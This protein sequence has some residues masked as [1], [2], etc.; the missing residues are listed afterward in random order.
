MTLISLNILKLL[1]VSRVNDCQQLGAKN[2]G[3]GLREGIKKMIME[4]SIIVGGWGQ[5]WTNVPLSFFLEKMIT[6]K[7][8][9]IMLKLS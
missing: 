8:P 1:N 7:C 9:K 6:C 4:N 5:H 3:Y 2:M